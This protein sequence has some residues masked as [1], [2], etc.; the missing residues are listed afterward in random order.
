[1]RVLAAN[2]HAVCIKAERFRSAFLFDE[3]SKQDKKIDIFEKRV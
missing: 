3:N 1:M 2:K